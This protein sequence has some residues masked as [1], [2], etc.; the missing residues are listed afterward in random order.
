MR[1]VGEEGKQLLRRVGLA[2]RLMEV[3]EGHDRGESGKTRVL[4]VE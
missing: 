4:S 1:S 2:V 3:S